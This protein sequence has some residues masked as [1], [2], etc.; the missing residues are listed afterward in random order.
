LAIYPDAAALRSTTGAS[1]YEEGAS[2]RK[3]GSV[4]ANFGF[5]K[6]RW[7]VPDAFRGELLAIRPLDTDGQFG[8]FFGA[9]QIACINMRNDV[10]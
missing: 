10:Q 1:E 6:R 4:K 9:H 2:L 8:A 7:R 3:A 5:G